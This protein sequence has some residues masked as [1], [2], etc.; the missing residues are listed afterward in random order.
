MKLIEIAQTLD[1]ILDGDAD[2]EIIDV[3]GIEDAQP[4]ELTFLANRKYVRALETTRA[5]A[6]LIS[7]DEERPPIAALRS[8][9]PYLDFA[10]AIELFHPP[11]HYAPSVHPTALIADSAEIGVGAHIGPYCYIADNVRIGSHAVLHSFVTIYRGARIGDNFFAHSHA[12]VREDCSIGHRVILQ[13]GV[14]VGSDGFGFA[15]EDSGSWY[16]MRQAGITR[17][18]D[19]VEIQAHSAIDRATVGETTIGRGTK[20]DNLVQVGH[21]CKIGEDTLLCG[22]VGLAG[23]TRVGNRCVLAGQVGAAGHLAIGDAATVTAQ[24][25]VPTD[26]PAGTIYSG[27]PAMENLAWR[28]SVAVF[29]RLPELQRELRDLRAEVARLRGTPS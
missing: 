12:C 11:L 5:S 16:K 23:T 24:S 7:K 6:I 29:H 8:S 19:D 2:L 22:Q 10:R 20:I 13:N 4:G 14:V 26:V 9:N 1:C 25:G 15:R 3:A 17:I 18:A 27:Y 21:A 28:K